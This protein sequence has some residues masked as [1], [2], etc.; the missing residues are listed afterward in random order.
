MSTRR[1]ALHESEKTPQMLMHAWMLNLMLDKDKKLLGRSETLVCN[2]ITVEQKLLCK[3]YKKKLHESKI[4]FARITRE[5]STDIV[6]IMGHNHWHF[7]RITKMY[8]TDK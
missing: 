6:F 2:R 4:K 1:I 3:R 7:A 8:Q 5:Y